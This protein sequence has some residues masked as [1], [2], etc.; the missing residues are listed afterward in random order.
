MTL[1]DLKGYLLFKVGTNR[2][3]WFTNEDLRDGW[4]FDSVG[5]KVIQ[6][7]REESH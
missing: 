6:K 7:I 5:S 4:F 3:G 2:D 1:E